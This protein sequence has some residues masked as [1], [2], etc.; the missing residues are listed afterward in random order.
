MRR[1]K[2]ALKVLF[3]IA[4]S[5]FLTASAIN[6]K[7]C[8][9][10]TQLVLIHEESEKFDIFAIENITAKHKVYNDL[11][12]Y[13]SALSLSDKSKANKYRTS[14][15]YLDMVKELNN[16]YCFLSNEL[17]IKSILDEEYDRLLNESSKSANKYF[18]IKELYEINETTKYLQSLSKILYYSFIAVIVIGW[19]MVITK[20]IEIVVDWRKRND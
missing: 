17:K 7:Y 3:V 9:P 1:V 11:L 20:L 15:S 18:P 6:Q 4:S 2:V 10:I 14:F 13:A 8:K 16:K 19:I 5:I 12:S